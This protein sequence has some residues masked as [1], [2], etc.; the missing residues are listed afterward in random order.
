MATLSSIHSIPF[1]AQSSASLS[2]IG[3]DASEMSVSPEQN[4]AKPSPVPGPSTEIATPGF[5][6]ENFSAL[7]AEMG[8]TVEEPEITTLPSRSPEG[9]SVAAVVSVPA[10]VVVGSA[11]SSSPQAAATS[12][13]A[14]N[15]ATTRPNLRDIGLVLLIGV[16]V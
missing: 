15:S 11:S 8:S 1:A 13:S 6:A 5:A 7:T 12:A 2:L 9:V 3:R 4:S 14:S 10:V 16:Q